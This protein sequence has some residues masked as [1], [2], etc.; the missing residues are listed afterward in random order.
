MDAIKKLILENR[1]WSQG[2]IS[3]D[4]DY[5]K[6][7]A[8]E[9]KP[10][11]LWIGFADSR[12]PPDLIINS[13]PGTLFAH[14]NMAN[15]VYEEDRNLMSVIE[16]AVNFLK[17]KYIVVCGHYNCGGVQAAFD[18]IDNRLLDEWTKSIQE[19][20]K[21]KDPESFNQ[22]VEMNVEQQVNNL[23]NLAVYKNAKSNGQELTVLGMVYDLDSGLLK[24]L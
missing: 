19:L 14:R 5:F 17:V 21:Q 2:N 18:G 10:E 20:K 1:A 12:V 4:P 23:E 11:I 8:H 16:Y 9:E 24:Q 13:R 7:M 6:K 22:L 3:I 15:L